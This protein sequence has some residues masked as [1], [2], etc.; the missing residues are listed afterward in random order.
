MARLA[1]LA[2]RALPTLAEPVA[3]A[4]AAPDVQVL[5]VGL[6]R[7]ALAAALAAAEL[8]LEDAAVERPA[9]V[10]VRAS[11]ASRVQVRVAAPQP[12]AVPVSLRPEEEL[13]VA[14]A[15]LQGQ[16]AAS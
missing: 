1:K 9:E 14:P 16:P 15:V 12:R 3:L 2:A 10:V 7:S 11:Q 6:L 8:G 5:Q 4:A 13:P